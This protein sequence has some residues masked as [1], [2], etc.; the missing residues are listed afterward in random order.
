MLTQACKLRDIMTE[1]FV[2]PE[3][4]RIFATIFREIRPNR[5]ERL[6]QIASDVLWFFQ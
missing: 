4:I 1:E 5:F 3:M 6:A 2:S